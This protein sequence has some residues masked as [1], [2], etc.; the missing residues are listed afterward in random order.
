MLM[1]RQVSLLQPPFSFSNLVKSLFE[2]Q[3]PIGEAVFVSV[4]FW[5]SVWQIMPLKKS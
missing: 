3:E 5:E 4:E 2:D 1:T